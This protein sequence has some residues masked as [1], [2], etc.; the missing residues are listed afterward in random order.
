MCCDSSASLMW[1]NDE[2]IHCTIGTIIIMRHSH[3][4]MNNKAAKKHKN[5]ETELCLRPTVS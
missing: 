2:L 1:E 5:N 4:N 3:N